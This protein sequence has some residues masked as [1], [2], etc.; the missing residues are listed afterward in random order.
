MAEEGRETERGEREKGDKG[1]GGLSI[2]MRS[3]TVALFYGSGSHVVI[4]L[5]YIL[6]FFLCF[7]F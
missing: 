7:I 2:E 5:E 6:V 4:G 1:S 3:S